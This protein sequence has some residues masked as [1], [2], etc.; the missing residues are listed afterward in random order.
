VHR[1]FI[2]WYYLTRVQCAWSYN[3]LDFFIP[4]GCEFASLDWRATWW[5]DVAYKPEIGYACGTV[6][7]LYVVPLWR[8]QPPISTCHIQ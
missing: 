4:V 8:Q 5:Q 6:Y 3:Y 2:T 1:V 7:T